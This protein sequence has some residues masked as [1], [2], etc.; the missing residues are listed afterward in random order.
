MFRIIYIL[1]HLLIYILITI[2]FPGCC[3]CATKAEPSLTSAKETSP[4]ETAE[5]LNVLRTEM[6]VYRC[7]TMV[8]IVNNLRHLGKQQAIRLLEDYDTSNDRRLKDQLNVVCIC[9][10]LFVA[11]KTGWKEPWSEF[12]REQ[13]HEV[14]K[15]GLGFTPSEKSR[16][17]LYPMALS[18]GVPF[19]LNMGYATG[20]SGP[21]IP[22]PNEAEASIAK[23]RDLELIPA[24]LPTTG[25]AQAALKLLKSEDYRTVFPPNSTDADLLRNWILLE[26]IDVDSSQNIGNNTGS[27]ISWAGLPY[28][29]SITN[30]GSKRTIRSTG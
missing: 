8:A 20:F 17:P 13:G 18:N 3:N 27:S 6:Q 10:V 1:T 26:A 22:V 29:N 23:C 25:Y 24:D 4:K 11:P 30:F 28:M 7:P 14:V 12:N 19:L 15:E 2:I 21:T 16:F 9:R 5:L